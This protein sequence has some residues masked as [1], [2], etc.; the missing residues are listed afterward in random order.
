MLEKEEW[1]KQKLLDIEESSSDQHLSA[2]DV[3]SRAMG[4]EAEGAG[5]LAPGEHQGEAT[6]GAE[7]KPDGLK[8]TSRV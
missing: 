8:D 1:M 3:Q 2:V 7:E 4:P 5:A 6:G